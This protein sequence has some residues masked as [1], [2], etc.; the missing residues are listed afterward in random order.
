MTDERLKQIREI[1]A[2][3]PAMLSHPHLYDASSQRA[4]AKDLLSFVDE[5]LASR[6]TLPI[7][8]SRTFTQKG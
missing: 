3:P 5:L 7:T 2:N 8:L 6:V 4:A 1:V